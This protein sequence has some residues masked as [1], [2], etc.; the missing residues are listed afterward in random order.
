MPDVDVA[1]DLKRADALRE[2]G[3]AV[4]AIEI[5]GRVVAS[6]P[7]NHQA[8]CQ[9]AQCHNATK[10][11]PTMLRAANRAIAANPHSEWAHRLRSLALHNMRRHPEAV[12][13]ARRSIEL[14]PNA[15]RP[16]MILADAALVGTKPSDKKM[17]YEA[18]LRALQIAPHAADAHVT[19]GRVLL[20]IGELRHARRYF[21]HALALDPSNAAALTNLAVTDL[22]GGK[23]V[24]AGRGF[25]AVAAANPTED[26]YARNVGASAFVW[27]QSALDAGVV[28]VVTAL[29]VAMVVPP[30]TGALVTLA[31]LVAYVTV[32]TI[33]YRRLP[34][35]MRRLAL[36]GRSP[37]VTRVN[38]GVTAGVLAFGLW[39]A[40]TEAFGSPPATYIAPLLL[41]SL[42]LLW[43][44]R[45]RVEPRLHQTRQRR[46]YRAEVFG[47]GG[48]PSIVTP[49]RPLD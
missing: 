19:M 40:A 21:A 34:A 4:D 26:M 28:I 18:A 39:I 17:A 24:A 13:A 8:L 45:I 10:D 32:G 3:R 42:A 31:L 25:G 2:L 1:S 44:L 20:N 11:Y 46:R 7:A 22:R 37:M 12:A 36:R 33:A 16:H 23:V 48:Q 5:L 15:W 47:V 49:R 29:V 9:L 38:V 6:E 35:P 43:R 41:W 27:M 14:A 30:L